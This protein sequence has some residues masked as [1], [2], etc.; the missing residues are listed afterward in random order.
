MSDVFGSYWVC[1]SIQV[2]VVPAPVQI[3]LF[4]TWIRRT[5]ENLSSVN[6]LNLSY[7]SAVSQVRELFILII[8][9]N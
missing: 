4:V 3:P 5:Q 9:I 6:S 8:N 1:G 2:N 7:L